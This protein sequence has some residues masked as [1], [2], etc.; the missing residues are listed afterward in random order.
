M[1]QLIDASRGEAAI[2]QAMISLYKRDWL[3]AGEAGYEAL[4]Q[5][6]SAPDV[7]GMVL[8]A[9]RMHARTSGDFARALDALEPIAGVSWDASGRPSLADGS[10][11][12]D[13]AVALADLLILD[14]QVE[15]GR[16]LLAEIIGRMNREVRAGRS[17]HWYYWW[18]PA[19]LALNGDLEA[20][21]AM[22]ERSYTNH[23]AMGEWWSDIEAE[24][25]FEQLRG[26]PR[27]ESLRRRIRAYVDEQRDELE[28]MRT[29]GL[30]PDRG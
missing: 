5:R 8:M 25:A 30:V 26:T 22:L 11:L 27:F 10:P 1:Q 13:G 28:R 23:V 2:P 12:R 3:R 24:P 6:T 9:I 18:H 7:Q 20:A 15:R 4:A 16:R 29:E 14:G 21:M 19:A 17:E